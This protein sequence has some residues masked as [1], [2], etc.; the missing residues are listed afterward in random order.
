MVL[1]PVAT[2]GDSPLA[3]VVLYPLQLA[4]VVLFRP[5]T[6]ADTALHLSNLHCVVVASFSSGFFSCCPASPKI[7]SAGVYLVP[8]SLFSS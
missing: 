6:G 5:A 4:L 8:D 2:S 1:F 7:V 3:Q